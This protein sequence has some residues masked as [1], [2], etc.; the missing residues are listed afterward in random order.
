M[1][2]VASAAVADCAHDDDV[3]LL[4]EQER[5]SL[6]HDVVVVEEVHADRLTHGDI[7]PDARPVR[8]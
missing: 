8:A 1:R 3:L 5:E 6:A 2:A 7:P 4:L